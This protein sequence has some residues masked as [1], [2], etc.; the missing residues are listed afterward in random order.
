[1]HALARVLLLMALTLSAPVSAPSQ[2]VSPQSREVN[3]A[4]TIAGR[5]TVN[6]QV[7]NVNLQGARHE[8]YNG[9]Y[10]VMQ[11]DDR[12]VYRIYGLPPGRYLVSAGIPVGRD[13]GA[14]M[15][16]GNSYYPQTFYP[17]VRDEAKAG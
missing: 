7:A 5:V 17:G 9:N 14:S 13:G 16:R 3:A 15:G 11:T 6:P 10:T 2:S 12:G 4:G 1:M 8:P